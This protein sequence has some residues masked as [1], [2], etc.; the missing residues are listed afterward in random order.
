MA[1]K[2]LTPLGAWLRRSHRT[3]ADLAKAL[4]ITTA[5]MSNLVAGLRNPSADL[6]VALCRVTGLQAADLVMSREDR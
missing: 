4:G 2:A 5:H 6:L 1:D 3:Q